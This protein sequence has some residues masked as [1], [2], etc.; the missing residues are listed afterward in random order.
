MPVAVGWFP[1]IDVYDGIGV[2]VPVSSISCS[3]HLYHL[4]RDGVLFV[5]WAPERTTLGLLQVRAN[6][7]F[8]GF[9][10]GGFNVLFPMRSD[11]STRR[12]L[13]C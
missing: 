6:S 7:C 5:E 11:I 10:G 4:L 3:P 13:C 12:Y 2:V 1:T 9:L 8:V